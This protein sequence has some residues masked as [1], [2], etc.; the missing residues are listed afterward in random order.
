MGTIALKKSAKS[1]VEHFVENRRPRFA[2]EALDVFVFFRFSA[3]AIIFG[4][5]AELLEQS[6][7]PE[8][9]FR[10]DLSNSRDFFNSE[11]LAQHFQGNFL[12]SD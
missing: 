10:I 11:S 12:L 5:R 8:N 9:F 2:A 7:K 1:S 4:S 3:G 6:R